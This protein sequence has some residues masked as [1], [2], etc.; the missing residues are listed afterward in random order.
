MEDIRM[1][2]SEHRHN[3]SAHR[4]VEAM[5]DTRLLEAK[6]FTFPRQSGL[7]HGYFDR[8]P[9]WWMV[10][11]SVVATVIVAVVLI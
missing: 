11:M 9:R 8:G 2:R 5:G 10:G 7:P 3:E 6:H 4:I 1:N